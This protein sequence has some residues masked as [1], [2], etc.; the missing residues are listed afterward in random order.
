MSLVSGP[1]HLP[2]PTLWKKK[3]EKAVIRGQFSEHL[4][5]RGGRVDRR[6]HAS[7]VGSA[8]NTEE[9]GRRT[10]IPPSLISLHERWAQEAEQV[11]RQWT[12]SPS[13][14]LPAREAPPFHQVFFFLPTPFFNGQQNKIHSGKS[15]HGTA[16]GWPHQAHTSAAAH[17]CSDRFA[18]IT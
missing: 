2:P 6:L 5:Q 11:K 13:C 10:H 18:E 1:T 15:W 12:Q 3:K 16:R 17:T 8:G 14:A 7:S 4:W 9:G